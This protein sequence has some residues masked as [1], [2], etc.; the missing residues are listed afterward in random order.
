VS[1]LTFDDVAD[2]YDEFMGQ[3]TRLY[4]PALLRAAHVSPGQRVLDMATGT[5]EAALMA[6]DA[7]GARGTIVGVDISLPMLRGARAKPRARPIRLAAMNGQALALRHETFDTVISQLGLMFFP[8]PIAG[9]RE[10]R[11]VLRPG[12]RFAALVWGAL[13]QMPWFGALA[14]ELLAQFPARRA[15]LFRGVSLGAPG[16]LENVLAEAGLRGVSV[17][18]ETQTFRF[19]SFNDYWRH[20]ESG[21]IR[22]GVMLR[23]LPPET[24]RAVRGRVRESVTAFA[25]RDGLEFPTI[26]LVG[27]G[28]A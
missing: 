18:T 26:A 20:V 10:A 27:C 23:E 5:G 9:I 16:R 22:I 19:A 8:D 3:W 14:G 13:E 11:R 4:V 2:V 15:D 7:V 25:T 6:A 21:A 17:T 28:S 1:R 24:V 12:G